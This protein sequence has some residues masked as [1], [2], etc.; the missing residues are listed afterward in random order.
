MAV[1]VWS[2]MFTRMRGTVGGITYSRNQHW[3][4]FFKPWNPSHQPRT[5]LQGIIVDSFTSAERDVMAMGND[6]V[7]VQ[8]WHD[9]W[10]IVAPGQNPGQGPPYTD[11]IG[12]RTFALYLRDAMAIGMPD[13][14]TNWPHPPEWTQLPQLVD[15]SIT[16]PTS[17]TGFTVHAKNNIR[18]EMQNVNVLLQFDGPH[19]PR[20]NVCQKRWNTARNVV[21]P[22]LPVTNLTY[23]S[24]WDELY[25]GMKVF[26]RLKGYTCPDVS[27]QTPQVAGGWCTNELILEAT[28]QAGP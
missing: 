20:V 12:D 9:W 16:A 7:L 28:I 4:I 26:V 13:A 1:R 5:K 15:F 27:G 22:C 3:P 18:P 11:I 2:D 19:H 21:E 10:D 24:G 6:M 25:T 14:E 8:E 23:L 17:G